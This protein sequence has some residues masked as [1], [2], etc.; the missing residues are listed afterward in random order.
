MQDEIGAKNIADIKYS[1]IKRFYIHLIKDIGFKPNSMEIIHTIL[2][3][4]FN[5]AVRM[6]S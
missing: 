4:V 2:H 6:G 1:D 5:V 3:P